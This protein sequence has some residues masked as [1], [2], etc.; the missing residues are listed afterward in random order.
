MW[1]W[2]LVGTLRR[3]VSGSVPMECPIITE[4]ELASGMADAAFSL[5]FIGF[6]RQRPLLK[7][8]RF[9]RKLL[10]WPPAPS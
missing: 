1:D 3:I 8:M 7:V 9:G 6:L 5:G 10:K 4:M 2:R